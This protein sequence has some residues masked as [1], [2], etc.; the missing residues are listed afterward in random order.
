MTIKTDVNGNEEWRYHNNKFD[1][2]DS[3]N[4]LFT[5]K[6]TPD[7][8][9]IGGGTISRDQSTG[10]FNDALVVK[11]DSTG[12]LLWEKLFDF[13]P[14]DEVNCLLARQDSTT[15]LAI[16]SIGKVVLIKLDENGDTLWTSAIRDS[17]AVVYV[18]TIIELNSNYYFLAGVDTATP[19]ST[20]FHFHRIIKTNSLGSVVWIKN[21]Y[22]TS[23]VSSYNYWF[24]SDS[25]FYLTSGMVTSVYT[26]YMK[27]SKIDLQGNV[28]SISYPSFGGKLIQDSTLI[29]AR[30]GTIDHDSLYIGLGNYITG[31][32]RG[33]FFSL[34]FKLFF[35]RYFD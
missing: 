24:S 12:D 34:L 25:L 32:R 5:L 17:G 8:G 30:S 13:T 11:I 1:G 28:V 31:V 33:C 6:P 7:R 29:Y 26:H 21:Y 27:Q 4:N 10:N 9:F 14:Y 18:K 19:Q 3:S 15:I 23:S 16:T 35:V 20:L 2:L 22:D